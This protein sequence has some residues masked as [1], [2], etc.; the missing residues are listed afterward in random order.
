MSAGLGRNQL[1]QVRSGQAVL[2]LV[3]DHQE[4]ARCACPDQGWFVVPDSERLRIRLLA[5]TDAVFEARLSLDVVPRLGDLG[6]AQLVHPLRH[7]CAALSMDDSLV[8]WAQKLRQATFSSWLGQALEA[9]WMTHEPLAPDIETPFIPAVPSQWAPNPLRSRKGV[10]WPTYGWVMVLAAMAVMTGYVTFRVLGGS[11]V[12]LAPE[13]IGWAALLCGWMACAVWLIQRESVHDAWI[14]PL[15]YGSALLT[16]WLMLLAADRGVAAAWAILVLLIG[17]AY[18]IYVRRLL[19]NLPPID[20][21][22]QWFAKRLARDGVQSSRSRLLDVWRDAVDWVVSRIELTAEFSRFS[23]AIIAA[24]LALVGMSLVHP[25]VPEVVTALSL[26]MLYLMDRLRANVSVEPDRTLESV[27]GPQ[28]QLTLAGDLQFV[29][30]VYRRHAGEQPLLKHLSLA[31]P[32]GALV[33]LD[34]VEG[35]GLSTLK[36]LLFRMIAP[37]RGQVRVGGVDVAR[38]DPRALSR[39]IVTLEH[40]DDEQ[41]ARLIDWLLVDPLLDRTACEAHCKALQLTEA[42]EHLPEGFETAFGTVERVFGPLAM[43][44]LRLARALSRPSPVLWLDQWLIGL[45]VAGREHVIE[46]LVAR[47]GTRIVV[48]R[49]G[50][51]VGRATLTWMLPGV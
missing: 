36:Q 19:P 9:A 14:K 39:F 33:R 32:D 37:E 5:E 35:A 30:L 22:L 7:L 29:D 25:K 38:L 45:T 23:R 20:Y 18:V 51:L 2:V 17:L 4:V 3:F 43:H 34:S 27:E 12:L 16:C 44:R 42:L 15:G 48:D 46:S 49:S 28:S 11:R 31:C 50:V 41:T 24:G 10:S 21:P 6:R 8:D 26:A 13:S 40:P 47:A 1:W